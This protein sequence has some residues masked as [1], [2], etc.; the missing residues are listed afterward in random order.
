MVTIAVDAMG[1]DHGPRVTIP[2]VLSSL[3]KFPDLHIHLYGQRS[4][5]DPFL[6]QSPASSRLKVIHADQYVANGERPTS[7]LR[8]RQSSM[9]LSLDAIREGQVAG[10][11]SAGNTGAL[12]ACSRYVLKTLLGIDRPAL[13]AKIPS[14]KGHSIMLDLGANV[15]CDSENLLQFALM[16]SMVSKV[17]DGVKEPAVALLNIGSEEIKGNE[18][19]RLANALLREVDNLNYIGYVEGDD[20]YTGV[21]DVIVCNGFVGNVALKTSEG[22]LQFMATVIRSAFKKNLLTRIS[23]FLALKILEGLKD[24]FNPDIKNGGILLGV[25]GVVVK[26]HG[27]AEEQAFEQAIETTYRLCK[28]Q[29]LEKISTELDSG[30]QY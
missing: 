26:S 9:R 5:L 24:S 13:A 21:A 4:K 14:A 1:G 16:G 7:A 15:E 29:L 22:L 23:G 25:Q 10:M 30:Y 3:Q 18:E 17:L 20:I 8:K 11:V 12:V 19:I 28:K 27:K 2:A 6:S